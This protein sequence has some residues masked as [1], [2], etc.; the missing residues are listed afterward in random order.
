CE[1]G[2]EGAGGFTQAGEW[3]RPCPAAPAP[4]IIGRRRAGWLRCRVVPSRRG[5]PGYTDSPRI[6]RVAA[7]TIGGTT[8]VVHAEV[9]RGELLGRPEQVP[10]QRFAL[11]RRP[12]VPA[13]EPL[14]LEVV[15]DATGNGSLEEWERVDHFAD[16]GPEDRHFVLDEVAGEL[17]LGP[18]VRQ[19]DGAL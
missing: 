14:V 12:V 10:G 4:P 9:V 15:G 11:Q 7:Y 5:Q 18:A 1:A 6:D 13:E 16:S 8:D 19:P 17:Q 2:A 3:V